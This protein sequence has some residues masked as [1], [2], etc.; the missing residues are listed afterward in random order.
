MD[1]RTEDDYE[2][3]VVNYVPDDVWIVVSADDVADG[4]AFYDHVRGQLNARLVALLNQAGP[5][6]PS[7][8]LGQDLF[9]RVLLE[10]F[11]GDPAPLQPLRRPGVQVKAPDSY[12]AQRSAPPLT[13]WFALPRRERGQSTWQLVYQLGKDRVA[14]DSR[15]LQERTRRLQSIRELVL[16]L[17]V[18]LAGTRIGQFRGQTWSI[19]SVA[20]NWLTAALPFSCGSPA[21]LPLPA[22]PKQPPHVVFPDTSVQTLM[23]RRV[24][25]RAI[26]AVLDTCPDDKAVKAAARK[27]GGNPLLGAVAKITMNDPAVLPTG[28]FGH[29][30]GCLP[31]V[32]WN[33]LSGPAH[34]QPEHFQMVDHGLFALGLIYDILGK[35][36]ELHLIR[37]LNEYGI[38]DVLAINQALAMLPR[39]LLGSD[40]PS[41][42]GDKLVVNLSLGSE[43]PIPERLLERWL[44]TTAKDP[45]KLAANLPHICMLLDQIHGNVAD[46]TTWLTERGVLVVAAAGN[47]ALRPDVGG[48]RPPP[49]FPARYEDVLG[50]AAVSKQWRSAALYSNRGDTV[51][52]AGSGHIATFGGNVVP[53]SADDHAAE[54]DANDSLTGVASAATLAG[55]RTNDTGWARWSGTSFATPIISAVAARLWMTE[56]ALGP[57]DV[58]VALRQRFGH[59]PG[60]GPDPDFPLEVPVLLAEQT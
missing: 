42:D 29:L 41:P 28:Y 46:T 30:D 27:F 21:G 49:R 2:R 18:R 37:V 3:E 43:V 4:A 6:A 34:D 56:P 11:R 52:Q 50:V 1:H 32:Q 5:E 9:P 55:G 19:K 35:S 13:P 45:Q 17:N 59:D 16:L 47:D 22:A 12:S 51:I 58:A 10:R 48:D 26:V 14:L 39:L 44:P 31:R 25:G 60:A 53:S 33:M 54:T 15:Y 57:R 40:D 23:R 20:P 24:R 8:P 38:G 36:A 7:H